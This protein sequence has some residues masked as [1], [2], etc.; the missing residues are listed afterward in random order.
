M[1]HTEH[2]FNNLGCFSVADAATTIV[3]EGCSVG[4]GSAS[5]ST[6]AE[7][8]RELQYGCNVDSGRANSSTDA[9]F[10]Q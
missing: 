6:D 5:S 9:A 7:L 4:S 8:E 2:L 3:G 10:A 1:D